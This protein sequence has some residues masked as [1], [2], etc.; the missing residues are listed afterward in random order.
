M[1]E[2]T[3]AAL[4]PLVSLLGSGTVLLALVCAAARPAAAQQPESMVNKPA[5]AFTVSDL[6]NKPLE[7]SAFRGKVVLLNFWATWCGPCQLEMP[8]FVAWQTQYGARGL[9]VVGISMDDEAGPVRQLYRKLNLN[10]PVAVGDEKIGNLFGGVFG[11][12]VTYLID[13]QGKIVAEYR[14]E[15]DLSQMEK[16]IEAQ[17]PTK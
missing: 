16:Q 15:S 3:K 4:K 2:A 9:Q 10:Y 13:R 1:R 12:P 17:L 7:M 11:L 5:P 6:D 8:R 14:G